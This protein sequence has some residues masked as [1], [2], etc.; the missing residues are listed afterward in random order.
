MEDV[1]EL[2]VHIPFEGDPG[3]FSIAPSAYNSRVAEGEVEGNEVLLR[4]VVIDGSY[5]VQAHIDREVA[6]INWA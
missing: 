2:T 3:V 1:T 4:V 5:D 6:Q